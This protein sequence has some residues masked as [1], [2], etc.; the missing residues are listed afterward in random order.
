M[1]YA[2]APRD[3]EVHLARLR[4]EPIVGNAHPFGYVCAADRF[5][6]QIGQHHA[7]SSGESAQAVNA[8]AL[9]HVGSYLPKHRVVTVQKT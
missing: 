1:R 3:V 7:E 2:A 8:N 4:L 5:A 9:S 6:H